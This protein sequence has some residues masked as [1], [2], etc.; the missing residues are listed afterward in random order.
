M[1]WFIRHSK[2]YVLV[3]GKLMWKNA[4]EELLQKCNTQEEGEK[5]LLKI[6]AGSCGNYA[7]SRNLVGKAF[8]ARFYWPSAIVDAKAL[9]HHYEGCQFF[10][11]QIHVPAQALQT[12]LASWLFA[13][14]G[15]DM[16]GPFKS[17]SGGFRYVHIAIDKF[18]KWIEY[19]PLIT[20]TMKKVADLIEEIV[21]HFSLPN[22]TSPT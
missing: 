2:R 12:I 20:A 3:D 10:T 11:K 16:I 22:S 15:L 18:S 8:W 21:H 5:L 9:V 14:W 13:C 19:K 17:A 6:H 4:R 1:E 7:V